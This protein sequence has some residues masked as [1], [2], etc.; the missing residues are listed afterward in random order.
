ME[1]P[2]KAVKLLR[3]KE[4]D[5]CK[6]KKGQPCDLWNDDSNKE[7]FQ[8]SLMRSRLQEAQKKALSEKRKLAG[9]LG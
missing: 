5:A 7:N 2:L 3:C 1:E 6:R 9:L 8:G 4:C